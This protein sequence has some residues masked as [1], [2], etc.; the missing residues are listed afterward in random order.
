MRYGPR[1]HC[2]HVHRRSS[3]VFRIP[4]SPHSDNVTDNLCAYGLYICGGGRRSLSNYNID[5][6][7]QQR[8]AVLEPKA[9]ISGAPGVMPT[10]FKFVNFDEVSSYQKL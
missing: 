2:T 9:L 4:P 7:Q 5:S 6:V 10:V 3:T 8:Q 1:V